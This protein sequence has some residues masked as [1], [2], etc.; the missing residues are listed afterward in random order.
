MRRFDL[1]IPYAG[2]PRRRDGG[3]AIVFA[4]TP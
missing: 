1:L 2:A 3:P 4:T